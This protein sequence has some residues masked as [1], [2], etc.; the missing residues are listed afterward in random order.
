MG[1]PSEL[2][3][4]RVSACRRRGRSGGCQPDTL[5]WSKSDLHRRWDHVHGQ[6]WYHGEP[7]RWLRHQLAV[8]GQHERVLENQ[9]SCA[10]SLLEQVLRRELSDF[11]F[12]ESIA[13]AERS[14][15]K[16]T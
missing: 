11:E 12:R 6:L 10:P 2:P 5:P 4:D 14:L 1:L 3:A 16:Y 7:A 13:S 9:S 8:P 15:G